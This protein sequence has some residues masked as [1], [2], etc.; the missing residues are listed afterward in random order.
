MRNIILTTSFIFSLISV[1]FAGFTWSIQERT[2]DIEYSPKISASLSGDNIVA[3]NISDVSAYEINILY[4]YFE[5]LK[6]AEWT[7]ISD[8]ISIINSGQKL[9]FLVNDIFK[10]EGTHILAVVRYK[11]SPD[12]K[13]FEKYYF[14]IIFKE[15]SFIDFAVTSYDFE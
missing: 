13:D 9:L 3:E 7:M 12:D 5:N 2:F 8:T 6:L 11:I 1:A 4:Y 14:P 10:V 15:D